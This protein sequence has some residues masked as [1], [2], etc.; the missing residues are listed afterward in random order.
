MN[1][2]IIKIIV[3]VTAGLDF[4][5][6][7][8]FVHRD[9]K[10]E[11]I[12]FREDGSPVILDFGIAKA[13]DG[14]DK[15]T[16]TG[17]IVGT[18]AYMSPE[19]AQGKKL[20]ERS[21]LYSLG[22]ML[23]EM[24]MGRVPF[25]G[26][27]AVAVLLK[28]V[29]EPPPPLPAN[30]SVLQPVLDKVLAKDPNDRYNRGRDFIE[31]LEQ[32]GPQLKEMLAKGVTSAAPAQFT[33]GAGDDDA[34]MAADAIS[35]DATV[36]SNAVT[37]EMNETTL[38]DALSDAKATIQD[39]S[40]EAQVKKA[41]KSKRLAVAAVFVVVSALSYVGYQQ[42][43]IAPME[44][45]QAQKKIDEVKNQS[46]AKVK[47]LLVV[48][49]AKLEQ[50]DY[51][52]SSAIESLIAQYREILNL[53][54]DNTIAKKDME[55]MGEQFSKM[56]QIELDKGAVDNAYRY[57]N[58]IQ[59]L[60]PAH[61]SISTLKEQI[62]NHRKQAQQ[63]QFTAGLTQQQVDN[64][65][66]AAKSDINAGSIFSP[67]GANAYEKYQQILQLDPS[68]LEAKR[69][70]ET[71]MGDL[72]YQTEQNID[73]L[74]LRT[75][76][77]NL[78]LLE[79]YSDDTARIKGLKNNYSKAKSKASNLASAKKRQKQKDALLKK[80]TLLK[81]ERLSISVNDQLRNTYQDVL[82]IESSNAMAKKGLNATSDYEAKLS[83]EAIQQRD[84]DRAEQHLLLISETTPSYQNLSKL[85]YNVT[86]ARQNAQ[87][88][89]SLIVDANK[90]MK[91][92]YVDNEKK[93]QKYLEARTNIDS[94]KT[95]DENNPGI[96][97]A[98][99]TLENNYVST[100]STLLTQ[101]G[102][103]ELAGNF[104]K[105]TSG[106]LWPTQRLFNMQIAQTDAGKKKP[107]PKKRA[108]TGGF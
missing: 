12:M 105:D 40:K 25:M 103:A 4:A 98:L 46:L 56:A 7:K 30:L 49:S 17:T 72:F 13:K 67:S 92:S 26:D 53:D 52:D 1:T 88:A 54:T 9:I 59:E 32:L 8:G 15:M 63:Q 78:A 101:K 77:Q 23:Y 97:P 95:M 73:Q 34:T 68:H 43:Y 57:L 5:G 36:Q 6:E 22:I 70:M 47:E 83:N 87:Q 90:L 20:D 58:Y 99:V 28:H 3:G 82:A 29:N 24:L 62:A 75:A 38:S 65:L 27:S 11:N 51:N 61:K 18:T 76:S 104:L 79:R 66:S 91:T 33:M 93:R 102:S 39:F 64:L 94:A 41:K 108:F 31:H 48:T 69:Q 84:F 16:K 2:E 74:Q 107:K 21:D 35:D 10:P 37:A 71:L 55:S 86:L 81:R 100:I 96:D 42:L 80:A 19:Q 89:S 60:A 85:K 106:K 50:L 44:R 45:T 14:N